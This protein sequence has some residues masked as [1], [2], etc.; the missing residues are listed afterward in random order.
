[1]TDLIDNSCPS[2][3][4]LLLRCQGEQLWLICHVLPVLRELDDPDSIPEDQLGAALAYLEVLWIDARR[5]A[6]ETD[7]A[8]AALLASE[9][10]PEVLRLR[11]DARRYHAAVRALREAIER[12]YDRLTSVPADQPVVH[13]PA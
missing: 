12:R 10:E 9:P 11:A 8:S 7:K 2:D 6:H 1:M 13:Q 3:V 5:M 4:R